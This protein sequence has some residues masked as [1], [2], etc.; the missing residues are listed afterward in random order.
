[1]AR[2]IPATCPL[3]PPAAHGMCVGGGGGHAALVYCS[4]LQLAAPVGR[5]PFA[6]VCLGL[7][8]VRLQ[9][10]HWALAAPAPRLSSP[11]VHLAISWRVR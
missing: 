4:R 6:C 3:P 10:P 2:R 1:M 7:D 8:M 5:S 11:S 9:C